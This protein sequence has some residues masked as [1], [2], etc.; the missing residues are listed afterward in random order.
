MPTLRIGLVGYGFAADLHLPGYQSLGPDRCRVVGVCGRSQE[1]AAA[2]AARHG[3]P[4]AF[5]SMDQMLGSVELDA[6]DLSIPNHLHTEFIIQAAQAGKHIICEKHLTGYFGEAQSRRAGPRPAHAAAGAQPALTDDLI[7]STTSRQHM[8]DQVLA[9]CEAIGAALRAAGVRFCY[10]ENWVYA[11]AFVKLRRLADAAGGTILRIEAEES[12]SGSGSIYAKRWR[13]SGGGSL[14]LKGAH[15]LGAVLQL[16]QWEGERKFGRPIRPASVIC[17]VGNLTFIEAFKQERAHYLKDDWQDV[18][19][20]GLMVLTFEDGSV[21]EVKA[22]DT[23]L[24]GVHNYLE[25]Y[26]SNARLRANMNPN[27]ACVAYA[28][29]PEIFGEEYISEKIETKGGWTFPSPDEHWNQGYL[30]EIA[31]FVGAISE[32][33]EPISGFMLARDVTILLYAAYLS[34]EQGR[35]VDL[36]PLL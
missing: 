3:I 9:D 28:P 8:L 15:P 7:G 34:A 6:V 1:R 31:D 13:T 10:A 26:L 25:A 5:V 11:P 29:A 12:H 24:G 14:V 36:R 4:Q 21:A 19:D 17:E 32:G 2:F 23:T 22:G 27:N 20:W 16:K 30:Q 33:R 35:R 18:E